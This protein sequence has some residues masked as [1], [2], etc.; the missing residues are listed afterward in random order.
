LI[1]HFAK[2]GHFAADNISV[3][4][5][6]FR[7]V[8][9]EFFH[10]LHYR[11]LYQVSQ[12]PGDLIENRLKIGISP[13]RNCADT[14]HHEMDIRYGPRDFTPEVGEIEEIALDLLLL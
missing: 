10:G 13:G 3:T 12:L 14:A 11:F 2:V 4:G 7:H 9:H 6:N 1:S 8:K 5:V